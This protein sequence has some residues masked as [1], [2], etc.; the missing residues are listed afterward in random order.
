[1]N[2]RISSII[3]II[4]FFSFLGHFG[5]TVL[6]QDIYYY[7]IIEILLL[8]YLLFFNGLK[9]DVSAAENKLILIFLF[10][11]IITALIST[12][13]SDVPNFKGQ[14]IYT[15]SLKGLIYLSLNILMILLIVTYCNNEKFFNSFLK[16]LKYLVVFYLFYI[17]LESYHDYVSNNFVIREILNIFHTSSRSIDKSFLNLLGHEHSNSSVFVLILYAYLITNLL[18]Q[19]KVFGSYIIDAFIILVLVIAL[20][21][22]ESKLGY[23]IFA[24]LNFIIIFTMLFSFKVN[25]RI[26]FLLLIFALVLYLTY[27]FFDDKVERASRLILNYDHPSFN[28]RANFALASL[29]LM[30]QY[31]ILGVGLNNFKF[32]LE[33]A[34]YGLVSISWIN[35]KTEADIDG[36]SALELNSYLY[37]AKGIPDPSNMILGIGAEVG[38]FGLLIFLFIILYIFLKSFSHMRKKYLN[39]NEK[40]LSQFLFYS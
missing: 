31:P 17:A 21:L 2:I 40:I 28:I 23:V 19:K 16:T 27:Q 13:I 29:Y 11:V 10:I 12:L 38:I 7:Y 8:T 14:S 24:I 22:L 3:N 30:Y 1:M 37:S 4:I 34:I 36:N 18:N 5:V 39:Q 9:L 15:S 35:I 6:G 25:F 20:F 33:E 26:F 32:Y